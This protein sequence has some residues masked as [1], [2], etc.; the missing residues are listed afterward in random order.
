MIGTPDAALRLLVATCLAL[1]ACSATPP[2]SPT[3]SPF[4]AAYERFKARMDARIEQLTGPEVQTRWGLPD[5]SEMEGQE[6]CGKWRQGKRP[7]PM[8]DDPPGDKTIARDLYNLRASTGDG[9]EW[10]L[11]ST[12]RLCFHATTARLS[13]W[14]L[15]VQDGSIYSSQ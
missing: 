11:T 3:P 15:L 13:R 14:E 7:F 10:P 9:Y 1:S 4:V 8:I 6:V 12:L 2:P 5:S